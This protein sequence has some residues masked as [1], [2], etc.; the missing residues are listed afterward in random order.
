M[1]DLVTLVHTMIDEVEFLWSLPIHIKNRLVMF[2]AGGCAYRCEA[3]TCYLGN[4]QQHFGKPVTHSCTGKNRLI[5]NVEVKMWNLADP[6]FEHVKYIKF[7][8]LLDLFT[9]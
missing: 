4:S 2:S 3:K 9:D 6:I 1:Y 7:T 5:P 8:E